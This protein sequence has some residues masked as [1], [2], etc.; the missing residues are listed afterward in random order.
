MRYASILGGCHKRRVKACSRALE[1]RFGRGGLLL[2]PTRC[3]AKGRGAGSQNAHL[4]SVVDLS[5]PVPQGK[6]RKPSD[7]GS[8]RETP[9]P[10][11]NGYYAALSTRVDD[12]FVALL[13]RRGQPRRGFGELNCRTAGAYS[14]VSSIHAWRVCGRSRQ[15][16]QAHAIIGARYPPFAVSAGGLSHPGHTPT[17][18]TLAGFSRRA[19]TLSDPG[20]SSLECRHR[21][22][23]ARARCKIAPHR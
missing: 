2:C 10:D 17:H 14:D 9:R 15:G 22:A 18:L 13:F 20:P 6:W 23:P 5:S 11:P 1:P 12:M 3:Q 8:D 21:E 16:G 7:T 4:R 19:V